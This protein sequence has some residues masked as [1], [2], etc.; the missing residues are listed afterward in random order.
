M[1]RWDINS[2]L[3]G[4]G[5]LD[6]LQN[7]IYKRDVRSSTR[8]AICVLQK[9]STSAL[10]IEKTFLKL[11]VRVDN[12]MYEL[13]GCTTAKGCRRRYG[14]CKIVESTRDGS[15]GHF[16]AKTGTSQPHSDVKLWGSIIWIPSSI[17]IRIFYTAQPRSR[18]SKTKISLWWCASSW[19]SLEEVFSSCPSGAPQS[20][21]NI[22]HQLAMVP[23][24]DFRI[25]MPWS[26]LA[27]WVRHGFGRS[28]AGFMGL[29]KCARY[30]YSAFVTVGILLY[31]NADLSL[32]KSM[33]SP[34]M[35]VS[36]W[37]E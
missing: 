14:L 17:F 6:F 36:L 23:C 11:H 20:L 9:S 4:L 8:S 15:H 10:W 30:K 5:V 26:E 25:P 22:H 35:S 12:F 28:H 1:G 3:P 16:A 19:K 29:A 2:L 27:E 34:N 21:Q 13:H 18:R 24:S 7:T 37:E 31:K 33:I 32:S